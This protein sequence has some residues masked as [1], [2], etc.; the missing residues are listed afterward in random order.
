MA[1]LPPQQS[2]EGVGMKV[3]YNR[4]TDSLV[5]TLREAPIEESDEFRPGVIAGFGEDGVWSTSR[6]CAPRGSSRTPSECS[7]PLFDFNDEL[8]P[9]VLQPHRQDC[10]PPNMGTCVPD[11]EDLQRRLTFY[12]DPRPVL[13]LHLDSGR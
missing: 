5:I 7:S 1:M 8:R 3:I 4:E 12:P 11:P 13:C 9:I 10:R 2:V 6:C